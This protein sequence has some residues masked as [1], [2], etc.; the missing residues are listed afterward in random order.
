[1]KKDEK[2]LADIINSGRRIDTPSEASLAFLEV[3]NE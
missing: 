3:W 2:I 1:M